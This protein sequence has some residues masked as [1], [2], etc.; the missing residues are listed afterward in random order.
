MNEQPLVSIIMPAYNAAATIET[1]LQSIRRQ[2]VAD[3]IE[4]LV[5]DG[6]ST[7]AT[8]EIARRYGAIVLENPHR[9]PEPAKV[10]GMERAAGRYVIE[11]DT[12][13]EWIRPTQVEER[14]RLFAQHP[15]V[16]CVVCDTQHPGPHGGLAARYICLCGDPFNCFINRQKKGVYRTFYHPHPGQTDPRVLCFEPGEPAPIGDGGTTMFDLDWVKQEFPGEWDDIRFVCAMTNRIIQRTGCCGCIPGDDIRHH[17]K[18]G[19]ATY[20][21]K[22]RFRVQNNL[23]HQQESGFSARA[24]DAVN[25]RFAR[26]KYWFV[27]YA[28][29]VVGP[30]AD[31]IR[32]A[33]RDKDPSMLLHIVYVYYVCLYIAYC[34]LAAKLGKKTRVQSYGK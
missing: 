8:R 29:T 34:L 20:L 22:L 14:L 12:D 5:I 13:E 3:Q 26:R 16:R 21:S 7:D 2:T 19:F 17:V 27:L 23:F 9:L 1:V 4:I 6:G 24:A 10:I 31:S 30:L 32:M 33:M 15:E 11:Q 28:A 18:A 25:T